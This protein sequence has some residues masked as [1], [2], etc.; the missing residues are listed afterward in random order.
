MR[1]WGLNKISQW[2]DISKY[3]IF[4]ESCKN[5]SWTLSLEDEKTSST[6][7]LKFDDL[8]YCCENMSDRLFERA[9]QASLPQESFA[10][11][12]KAAKKGHIYAQYNLGFV[13]TMAKV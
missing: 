10:L 2:F 11:Y 3:K 9:K 7:E 13:I 1:I 8:P 4:A 12:K 5:G 6:I